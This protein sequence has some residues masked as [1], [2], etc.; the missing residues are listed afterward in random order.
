[1]NEAPDPLEAELAA[2]RPQQ[3]SPALAARIAE[4]L[5]SPAPSRQ[6]GWLRIALAAG[7][8]AASIAAALWLRRDGD[9]TIQ[10]EFASNLSQPAPA[11][12]FDDSLP[13]VWSYRSAL[14]SPSALE[15]LL[16]KHSSRPSAESNPEQTR[17]FV[18]VTM[19]LNS[20]LGEL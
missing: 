11:S 6:R 12:A 10:P 14:T 8:I 19:N 4:R 17:G 2:F 13:S 20:Q 16:D 18:P 1:M 3:P 9:R 5:Q 15:P 7:A